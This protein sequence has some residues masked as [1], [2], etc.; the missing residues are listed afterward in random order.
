MDSWTVLPGLAQYCASV[1]EVSSGDV[2]VRLRDLRYP[3]SFLV[4]IGAT[5]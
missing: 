4:P 5:I 1:R 2:A 3:S